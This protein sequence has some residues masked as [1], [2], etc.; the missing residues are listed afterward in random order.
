MKKI[1]THITTAFYSKIKP[2]YFRPVSTCAM[3]KKK[4]LGKAT[5]VVAAAVNGRM[6]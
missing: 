6:V 4:P 1:P 5:K 3:P 2:Q